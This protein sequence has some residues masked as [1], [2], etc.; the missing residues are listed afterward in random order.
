M[1]RSGI[2]REESRQIVRGVQVSRELFPKRQRTKT[3]KRTKSCVAT[4]L[5]R[6][7]ERADRRTTP[8]AHETNFTRAGPHAA[9]SRASAPGT[10]ASLQINVLRWSFD[11]PRNKLWCAPPGSFALCRPRNMRAIWLTSSLVFPCSREADARKPEEK[12]DRSKSFFSP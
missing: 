4:Q 2:A 3:A 12:K 5:T 11:S 6:R 10:I 7:C 1:G 8:A 9:P